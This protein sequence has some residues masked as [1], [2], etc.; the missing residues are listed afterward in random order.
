MPVILDACD[1]DLWLD[2]AVQDPERLRPLL[3]PFDA[4]RMTARPVNTYVNNARN[5]GP[6][7]LE[8]V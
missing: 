4:A 3:A 8:P 2:P 6:A 5:Q 1:Y 7:C